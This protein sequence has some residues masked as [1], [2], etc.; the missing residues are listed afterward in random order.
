MLAASMHT[1]LALHIRKAQQDD[2]DRLVDIHLGAFPDSRGPEPRRRNFQANAFGGLDDLYVA[3][4]GETLLGHAFLYPMQSWFGGRAVRLGGIASVGVAA[5]ARG[6]GIARALLEHL[7]ALSRAR[8]DAITLLYAFRHAFYRRFGYGAVT[9][10]IQLEVA[11]SAIPA[12]WVAAARGAVRSLLRSDRDEL[13]HI[14]ERTAVR[15]TGWLTRRPMLWERGFLDDRRAWFITEDRRGYLSWT[16]EKSDSHAAV[17]LV[18]SDF[19]A[20]DGAAWRTL[21]GHL[22]AQKDQVQ[23]IEIDV[24]HDDPALHA[25]VDIDSHRFG[26]HRLEH[27]YG[28]IQAGPMARVHDIAAALEARGYLDEGTVTV[29]VGEGP[30]HRLEVAGGVG[31]VTAVAHAAASEGSVDLLFSD[32]ATFASVAY[33]GLRPSQGARAGLVSAPD[34]LA[35]TRA[36]RLF[37]LPAFHALDSF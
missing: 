8:G 17:H 26:T 34:R 9:P 15:T 37:A 27:P 24:P 4:S 3:A 36:D 7:H 6:R 23:C 35:L 18:V 16:L 28:T 1:P 11:P 10:S 33:G 12:P 22:G 2:V 21:W 25:L 19:V 5:E 20:E 13:V 29:A 30:T 32:I 31:R 14:Y